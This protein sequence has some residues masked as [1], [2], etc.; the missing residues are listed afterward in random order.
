MSWGKYSVQTKIFNSLEVT[1]M[2][3]FGSGHSN[4]VDVILG[5]VVSGPASAPP[6]AATSM[7]ATAKNESNFSEPVLFI[8][9]SFRRLKYTNETALILSGQIFLNI[10]RKT[11]PNHQE[12]SSGLRLI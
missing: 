2:R 4:P 9:S 5:P 12:T 6:Q 10:I 1:S 7:L 8:S 3:G 11:I